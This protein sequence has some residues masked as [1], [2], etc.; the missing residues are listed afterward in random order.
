MYSSS[1]FA[2]GLLSAGIGVVRA[3]PFGFPLANGFPFPDE[4]ALEDLF[5]TAGGNFTNHPPA[6]KFDDDSLTSWKL[7][8]FNEFLEVAFFTQLIANITDTV[9]G[10]ELDESHRDYILDALERIQAQEEM[11]AYNANDAVRYFTGGSHILPCTYVFPVSDFI[12]A[13]TFA[14]TFTD[15]YLGLMTDIQMRTAERL[16]TKFSPLIVYVLSQALGQEGQQSG[17][18]RSLQGKPPSA[19]PFLTPSTRDFAFSWLQRFT[20][21]GSCPNATGNNAAEDIPLR[22]FPRLDVCGELSSTGPLTL[23]SY[24]PVDPE[25]MS[26]AFVNGALMPTV[27][28]ITIT[29]V[30][31]CGR[32]HM[33]ESQQM[34]LRCGSAFEDGVTTFTVDFPFENNVMQGLTMVAVVKNGRTFTIADEVSNATLYGP[35]VIELG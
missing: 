21:P 27:F 7:Q 14:Q 20:V 24:G 13:I 1:L 22:T 9:P 16:G 28:P 31:T 34:P 2:L 15:M 29:D 5:V 6:V 26:V 33:R 35:A 10:Y 25:T 18:F 11:H 12:S 23:C 19:E 4:G 3:G 8:A 30:S 32:S 17:W